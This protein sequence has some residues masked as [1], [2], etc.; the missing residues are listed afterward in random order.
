MREKIANLFS[1]VATSYD[2]P[3]ANDM[4]NFD[5]LSKQM[6]EAES[7]FESLK[8]KFKNMDQLALKD[9]VS[10]LETAN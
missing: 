8:K 9:K 1:K 6:K 2:R 4:E 5:R 3:S 10:F 7:T